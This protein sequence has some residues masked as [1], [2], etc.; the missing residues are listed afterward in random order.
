MIILLYI[1]V[2]IG[3]IIG[4]HVTFIPLNSKIQ[5]LKE[6]IKEYESEV[7]IIYVDK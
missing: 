2:V 1:S 6:K 5:E 7:N 3:F 4:F